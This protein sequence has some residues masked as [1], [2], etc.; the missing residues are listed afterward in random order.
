MKQKRCYICS[1]SA[2][3]RVKGKVRD[4]PEMH[5]LRCRSCGLVFLETFDHIDDSFY[6]NSRMRENQRASDW[7]AYLEEC[8]WDDE[9]RTKWLKPKIAGKA[10][11]D[12]GC[13]GGGFLS[14]IKGTAKK[15]L[16]IEKD[17]SLRTIIKRKL[18]I[19]VYPDIDEVADRFDFITMFHVLEHFKD[20]KDI[21]VKLS[22][23]LTD[24]G[25]IIIEV[26]NADDALLSLYESKPFSEFT[27]WGC[28][29]YLFNVSALK[30]LVEC[31]G[32]SIEYS[33]QV[34][35]YP[36]SNH[37]YWLAKGKPGGHKIWDFI[38]SGV[39]NKEYESKL[40]AKGICDT[41]IISARKWRSHK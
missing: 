27:Y 9:R 1:N 25:R 21:L 36:I 29:L 33:K 38:D 20:P 15:C 16:G 4:I 31:A 2:F 41:I 7:K 19:D 17:S 3:D 24:S 6:E 10:V 40:S 22:K 30:K 11:L 28:H 5:I 39:L 12:F 14:N 18:K 34:Q 32:L 35:R 37:L 26:P 8:A 13:G 23:L